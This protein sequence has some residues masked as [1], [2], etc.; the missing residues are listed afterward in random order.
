MSLGLDLP[1]MKGLFVTGTD[2][3][4]GKTLIAGGIA[5]LIRFNGKKV[6]VF[7]PVG[8]GCEHQHEGLVNADSEFLRSCSHCNFSL[9]EINPVGFVTPAA[10]LVCEEFEN[11]A[12]D[13][14]AIKAAY[15]KIS[16]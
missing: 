16:A 2:T 8:S 10:P 11:R 12:V 14:E 1:K 6:G 15:T 9:S 4:I 13:F 3:G 5:N 7:K